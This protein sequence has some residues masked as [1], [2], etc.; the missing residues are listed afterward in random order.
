MGSLYK[1]WRLSDGGHSIAQML[2]GHP[3]NT[4]TADPSE[5]RVLNVVEEMSIAAGVPVPTVY[6]LEE[7][8]INAFA[9]GYQPQDAVVASPAAR[10]SCS[11]ATSFKGSSRTSSRTF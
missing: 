5:R 6:L 7:Q 2:G 4:N 11:V 3:I 10:S 1:M 9:A 8:G